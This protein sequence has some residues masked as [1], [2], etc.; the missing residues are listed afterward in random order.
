MLAINYSKIN[1]RN[2]VFQEVGNQ[3][4]QEEIARGLAQ[5]LAEKAT[6]HELRRSYEEI[7]YE[8]LKSMSK[9][10]LLE[11]LWHG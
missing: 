5:K 8:Q 4:S 3:F 11:V 2:N 10:E 9:D 1:R 6:D 7:M